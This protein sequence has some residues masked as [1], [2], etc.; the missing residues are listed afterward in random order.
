MRN[1]HT[2]SVH[3]QCGFCA[4]QTTLVIVTVSLPMDQTIN[5]S[6]CGGELG[7][8]SE[9]IDQRAAAQKPALRD[10]RVPTNRH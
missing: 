7:V 3:L 1:D 4:T 2:L 6:I 10:E 5:C 9:V 8:R